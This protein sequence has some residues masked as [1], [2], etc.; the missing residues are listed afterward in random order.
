MASV[1]NETA[2]LDKRVEETSSGAPKQGDVHRDVEI[3]GEAVDIERVEKV[4]A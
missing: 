3:G 2:A 4:Y 1:A